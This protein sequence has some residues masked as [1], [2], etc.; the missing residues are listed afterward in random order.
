MAALSSSNKRIAKN[1][2]FL[3]F[4]SLFLLVISLYTS[5]VTLQVLGV[6]DYGIYQVVGGVVAMFSI[7][8]STLA[9]A[10][11][12]FITFSLGKRDF[13]ELKTTF[14]TS[15]TLHFILALIVVVLLEA[16]GI[17]FLNHK[18]NIPPERLT[19]AG[20]VM[21]FS[22]A[23]LFIGIISVPYNAA[24][25]AHERMSAFAYISILEGILKLGAVFLLLL[26]SWDKLLLFALMHFIIA[27]IIRFIYTVYSRRNFEETNQITLHLNRPLFK[28]MFA[29][30]GWNM[31]GQGSL[32][33][34]NQ[35]VDIVL[36]L[37]FGVVVNAAKGISNQVT[38]AIQQL[39]GNFTTAMK[40]QLTKAIAQ[41]DFRRAFNLIN[42]GSRYI[43]FMMLFFS[44]PIIVCAPEILEL[45]LGVVPEYA[46]EFVRWTMLYLLIDSL[47][48]L[49]IHSILSNGNIKV[50]QIIVGGT[51]LLAIP[52]VWL[53]LQL[54]INPLWGVWVNIILEVIC[55]GERLYYNKKFLKFDYRDYMKEVLLQCL[56]LFC[57]SYV[58]SKLFV[59]FISPNFVAS[60][61]ASIVITSGIIWFLGLNAKEH[62]IMHDYIMRRLA[63]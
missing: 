36:N 38:T 58:L 45:W 2:V 49:L 25:I 22:I 3:Y 48:R 27:L 13:R 63:R 18:I 54:D 14:S 26:I 39:V 32:V 46:V 62:K 15:V 17:W 28:E 5:R 47:S 60:L 50:Y 16:V 59:A 31:F 34:R 55:L 51:K 20:W 19:I 56:F 44:I 23:T 37:F 8:S 61:I 6:E 24:I 35:G 9:A 11:Q 52:L 29:F 30:A 7:L 42:N 57:I 43:F 33:L 1:T 4:R 10:T 12:R 41:N 21:Q 40:P 53:F